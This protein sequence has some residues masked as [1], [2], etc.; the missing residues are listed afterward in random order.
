MKQV[1]LILS[2]RCNLNCSYC[3]SDKQ[4]KKKISFDVFQEEF[5][6][7]YDSNEEYTFDIMGGEPLMQLDL[8]Y[9]FINYAFE[10][11]FKVSLITNALLLTP[12]II[13][14]LNNHNVGVSVSYDGLWQ[15]ERS[16]PYPEKRFEL[17]RTIK[18]L[19]VHAVWN[20]E[21]FNLLDN[22]KFL[23]E[24][25]G[26]N[27]DIALIRDIGSWNEYNIKQGKKSVNEIIQYAI[28]SNTIPGFLAHF[29]DPILRFHKKG[30]IMKNC[31][32]GVETLS[33]HD[34]KFY[35]CPRFYDMEDAIAD[36]QK[37]KKM[38]SFCQDCEVFN[39]CEK[40]C[41]VQQ[42][43]NQKPIEYLCE[44]YKHIY[45]ALRSN[46]NK[47]NKDEIRRRLNYV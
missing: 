17:I 45:T 15:G 42:L 11:N 44:M 26:V 13:E 27:P 34:N 32:A 4:S 22:H 35:S 5:L 29:V 43:Q 9:K 3:F 6:K 20:A 2:E 40:G 16:N 12:E 39:Y 8:V 24:T 1:S 10:R 36:E 21:Y 23:V 28:E 46:M 38:Y 30:Y 25:F 14:Y 7:I 33:F 18:K 47:L 19:K 37:S 41:L 31:G